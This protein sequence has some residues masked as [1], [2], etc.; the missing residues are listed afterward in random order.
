MKGQ[1]DLLGHVHKGTRPINYWSSPHHIITYPNDPFP[2]I[3]TLGWDFRTWIS[4]KV[5]QSAADGTA[6]Q[7]SIGHQH[8]NLREHKHS[9]QYINIRLAFF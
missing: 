1:W 3:I 2:N 8:M 4:E 9:D 6:M 5:V 7:L